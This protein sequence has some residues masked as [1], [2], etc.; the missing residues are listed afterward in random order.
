M[1][2]RPI[3]LAPLTAALQPGI[4]GVPNDQRQHFSMVL[5]YRLLV[6]AFLEHKGWL[7]S[8]PHYL[9][10]RLHATG[11]D[12]FWTTFLAPL[13]AQPAAAMSPAP[14]YTAPPYDAS[15]TFA[16]LD[17]GL[18]ASSAVWQPQP[19][20][21]TIDGSVFVHIFDELLTPFSAMLRTPSSSDTTSH[22]SHMLSAW[23]EELKPN[24]HGQGS[25]ATRPSEGA[26][27][28]QESVRSFLMTRCP[29]VP[30]QGIAAL[31]IGAPS[32]DSAAV[33]SP[34]QARL[35][36]DTLCSVRICDPAVGSGALIVAMLRVLVACFDTLAP[37]LTPLSGTDKDCISHKGAKMQRPDRRLDSSYNDV[38]ESGT[39]PVQTSTVRCRSQFVRHT[40]EQCLY[41]CDIDG[42]AVDIAR[43][44]LWLEFILAADQPL[45]MSTLNDNLRTG[46][47]L[48]SLVGLNGYGEPVVLEDVLQPA[49][50]QQRNA[51]SL[52]AYATLRRAYQASHDPTE[53]LHIQSRL[54][55]MRH[56]LLSELVDNH[57]TTPAISTHLLW[58][59]DF[60]EVFLTNQPGFDIL[61]ANPPY[62]RQE[63]ID[64]MLA[65]SGMPI[66]KRDLQNIYHHLYDDTIGGQ[67]DLYIFFSIRGLALVKQQG[68]TLCFMC[69]NAWLDG[70]YGHVLQRA[71]VARTHS[72]TMYEN[73]SCRSFDGA[74][75]IN[76]VIM[77]LRT[78]QDMPQCER[79]GT[80][81]R[82]HHPFENIA[83]SLWH[84]IA[85][86]THRS[87]TCCS[88]HTIPYDDL[89]P[90]QSEQ[91]G[92]WGAR[93]LRAPDIY[94]HLTTTYRHRFQPL[95][96]LVTLRFGLKTGANCFFHLN[97]DMC[98]TWAIE[99]EFLR[100]LF[101]SPRT[102]QSFIITPG[103][104]SQQVLVCHTNKRDLAGTAVLEYI[105]WG[106]AMGYHQRS[107]CRH[108]VRWYD[109]G[110]Q[111]PAEFVALR[112][113]NQRNWTP[114]LATEDA[115]V[116][117][118]TVFTGV[119]RDNRLARIGG[120]LLNTTFNILMTE[121]YG[122]V[123]L[124]AGLLT[125]YGPE[126]LACLLP[127]PLLF[128]PYEQ[129]LLTLFQQLTHRAVLPVQN[130]LTM[131]D[132]QNL[133]RMV[134]DVLGLTNGECDA[135]YQAVAMMIERRRIRST[136]ATVGPA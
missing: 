51:S 25:Y 134:C 9:L 41:G 19:H 88:L 31:I 30:H 33:L 94:T 135:L 122:R 73:Q 42:M 6:L 56:Q 133:D 90:Q 45:P 43:L 2:H 103:D 123:N 32:S 49:M 107:S 102:C 52:E 22:S 35:L 129:D 23:Y 126:I 109:I 97:R 124:G 7:D 98:Q 28:C 29:N 57:D 65:E 115:L 36:A 16:I 132:R 80:F 114:L 39:S 58:Q 108:R 81:V 130:E 76:T 128:L 120:V 66:C 121:I 113:R 99:N 117:G 101:R 8:N 110:R 69:S 100:P 70:A 112:F 77:L 119:F 55:T 68:G 15:T 105:R 74:A 4:H 12:H 24:R 60:P 34:S 104:F 20:S 27:M 44:C 111:P 63:L 64:Q 62:V 14:P 79:R 127:D 83:P 91:R 93:F 131:P 75:K 37:L 21:V 48:V 82:I 5:I 72:C 11:T 85:T 86:H 18:F 106:E 84:A 3:K 95:H 78:S 67:T 89:D 54:A 47:A 13:W 1:T 53:R 17:A 40:I 59:L 50:Q 46:D 116:V 10:D 87:D 125:T 61:V 92:H 38:L 136:T 118:D 26:V 71:I 96:A